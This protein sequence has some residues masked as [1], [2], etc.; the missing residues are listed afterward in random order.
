MRESYACGPKPAVDETK[1]KK[2][3]CVVANQDREKLVDALET[4]RRRWRTAAHHYSLAE[5]AKKR[6]ENM[7]Y[8][9]ENALED[10]DETKK[11]EASNV[12]S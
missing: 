2:K 1:K 3:S 4:A 10:Y 6:A 5:E 12:G 9:A 7:F 11:T 8:A